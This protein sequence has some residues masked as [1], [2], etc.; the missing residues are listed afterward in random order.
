MLQKAI[1][2]ALTVQP[3]LS[4]LVYKKPNLLH[5]SMQRTSYNTRSIQNI[6]FQPT[7]ALLNLPWQMR[8][9]LTPSATAQVRGASVTSGGMQGFLASFHNAT[10]NTT[11]LGSYRN[12]EIYYNRR[13]G[14]TAGL[15]GHETTHLL[16]ES[17]RLGKSEEDIVSEF[18]EADFDIRQVEDP[19][20]RSILFDAGIASLPKYTMTYRQAY[21]RGMV[22]DELRKSVVTQ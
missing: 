20:T 11:R 14:A 13:L 4:P 2:A 9:A 5:P 17:R 3:I 19:I 22:I 21:M 8:R 6:G 18:Q 10:S 16:L 15:F 7:N 12:N 1:V